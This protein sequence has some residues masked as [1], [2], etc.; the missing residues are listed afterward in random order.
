MRFSFLSSS[1]R[2]R[3]T[4]PKL[5]L[6]SKGISDRYFPDLRSRHRS[7]NLKPILAVLDIIL[8]L[9]DDF[10]STPHFW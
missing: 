5:E 1:V 2:W 8:G 7:Y 6:K 10:G 4:L 9:S 3:W